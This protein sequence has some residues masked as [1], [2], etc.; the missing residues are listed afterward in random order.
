M[1][2]HPL[3]PHL[4]AIRDRW[5]L[6]TTACIGTPLEGSVFQRLACERG[7]EADGLLWQFIQADKKLKEGA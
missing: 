4:R 5:Q 2:E 7:N 1:A 3:I 6:L